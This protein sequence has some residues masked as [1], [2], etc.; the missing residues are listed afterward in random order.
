MKEMYV[1]VY[2][3]P[4]FHYSH[5]NGEWKEHYKGEGIV[6]ESSPVSDLPVP[7]ED[8]IKSEAPTSKEYRYATVEQRYYPTEGED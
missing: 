4:I 1:I 2:Y 5:T 8:Y 3:G 6:H 7:V